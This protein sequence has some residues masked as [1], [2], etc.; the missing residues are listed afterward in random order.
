MLR[1]SYKVSLGQRS[2][3]FILQDMDGRAPDYTRMSVLYICP[4]SFSHTRFLQILIGESLCEKVYCDII[5]F[6]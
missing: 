3:V 2:F 4:G 1:M 5:E 6:D